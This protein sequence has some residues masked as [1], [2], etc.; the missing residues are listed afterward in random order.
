LELSRPEGDVS[1][2]EKVLK[3]LNLLNKYHP[4]HANGKQ[5]CSVRCDST[6]GK[7][8]TKSLPEKTFLTARNSFIDQGVV[9]FGGYASM[10]SRYM[11][12]PFPKGVPA[13][14]VLAEN[15]DRCA[16]ILKDAIY[17]YKKIAFV[18]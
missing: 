8:H 11:P 10:Y 7:G 9:V 1:R 18:M 17:I 3:R 5:K 15:P 16:T 4:L 12:E 13:F 2:W 14:D 6:S